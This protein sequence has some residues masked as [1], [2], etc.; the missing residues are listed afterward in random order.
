ME[1]I[2]APLS[3]LCLFYVFFYRT[4]VLPRR[5]EAIL[6]RAYFRHWA[7][8]R[9]SSLTRDNPFLL[10]AVVLAFVVQASR[11]FRAKDRVKIVR[12][13]HVVTEVAHSSVGRV[14][15]RGGMDRGWGQRYPRVDVITLAI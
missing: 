7:Q 2:Y 1:R 9:G 11:I 13:D 6:P 4:R 10:S 3:L 5:L 15:H 12:G 14:M 8:G